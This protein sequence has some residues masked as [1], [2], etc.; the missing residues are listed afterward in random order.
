[1]TAIDARVSYCQ[2]CA[3]VFDVLVQHGKHDVQSQRGIQKLFLARRL[4]SGN[5][6]EVASEG[7][8]DGDAAHSHGTLG[9]PEKILPH[10]HPEGAE[11]E[12]DRETLHE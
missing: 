1:M 12:A 7:R 5:L 11:E 9:E 4:G 8:D 2:I 3:L 10:D 6:V